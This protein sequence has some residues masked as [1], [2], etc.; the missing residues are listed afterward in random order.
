[1]QVGDLRVAVGFHGRADPPDQRRLHLA[2]EQHARGIR[3]QALRPPADQ[4]RADQPHD[5]VEPGPAEPHAGGERD[6]GEHRCERIGKDV[7]VRRTQVEVMLMLAAM[8]FVMTLVIMAIRVR[9]GGNEH[10]R[11]GE[12]HKEPDDRDHQRGAEVD[13][14]R[15]QQAAN[16]LDDHR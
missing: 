12:V 4:P 11:R 2:V 8:A 13:V 7:D 14:L 16:R 1:M 10:P 3:D 9:T 15:I 6:D 5:G